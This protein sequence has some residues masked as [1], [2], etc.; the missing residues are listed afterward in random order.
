MRPVPFQG[1]DAVT[2]IRAARA[3]AAAAASSVTYIR[4]ARHRLGTPPRPH[5]GPGTQHAPAA[6][7]CHH[8]SSFIPA[9]PLPAVSESRLRVASPSRPHPQ[10]DD[11]ASPIPAPPRS[12]ARTCSR[13]LAYQCRTDSDGL[14]SVWSELDSSQSNSESVSASLS[15]SQSLTCCTFLIF[16]CNVAKQIKIERERQTDRQPSSKKETEVS[17][18]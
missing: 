10:L 8:T 1:L 6:S 12:P 15:Q 16:C 11:L 2:Y 3:T 13:S 7:A 9:P 5:V 14:Q 17:R 4:A 18:A